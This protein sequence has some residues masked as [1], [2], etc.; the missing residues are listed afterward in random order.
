MFIAQYKVLGKIFDLEYNTTYF[1]IF[2]FLA[3]FSNCFKLARQ[4][5]R[6]RIFCFLQQ[7]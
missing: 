7:Q 5:V 3:L 2:Y 1:A 4:V 6:V